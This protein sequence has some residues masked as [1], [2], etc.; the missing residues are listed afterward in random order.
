MPKH[1]RWAHIY[2]DVEKK[3]VKRV[4]KKLIRQRSDDDDQP[5]DLEM[6]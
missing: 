1:G 6:E 5:D 4:D 3:L 2:D